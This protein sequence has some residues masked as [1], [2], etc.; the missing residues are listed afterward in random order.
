MV[1]SC[2]AMDVRCSRVCASNARQSTERYARYIHRY[3]SGWCVFVFMTVTRFTANLWVQLCN[4]ANLFSCR[5]WKARK[6]LWTGVASCVS[7]CPTGKC[8]RCVRNSPM[9]VCGPCA[10]EC[11]VHWTPSLRC[12]PLCA[13]VSGQICVS[14]LSTGLRH[15]GVC[16]CVR[17][18]RSAIRVSALCT[19]LCHW[20][21]CP[22]V[23]RWRSATCQYIKHAGAFRKMNV[24][25]KWAWA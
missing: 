20:G 21:V 19:G 18:F 23:H 6:K 15:W 11:A 17:G 9:K 12:V 7:G 22:S 1:N 13:G 5:K 2:V 25:R 14:A 16:P 4:C 10:D 8:A 3:K 24:L